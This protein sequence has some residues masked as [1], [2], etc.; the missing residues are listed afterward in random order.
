MK[1]HLYRLTPEHIEDAK[2]N[3]VA[4]PPMQFDV[5]NHDDL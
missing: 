1:G 2:G 5:R 3:P 4:K